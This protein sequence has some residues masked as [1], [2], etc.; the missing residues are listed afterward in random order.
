MYSCRTRSRLSY[1]NE[2]QLKDIGLTAADV[3]HE[4]NKP[5]WK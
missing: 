1:L 3:Y 4:V 2:T 5:L